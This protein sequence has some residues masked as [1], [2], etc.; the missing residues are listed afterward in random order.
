MPLFTG[1]GLAAYC[2]AVFNLLKHINTTLIQ[3]K[4]YFAIEINIDRFFCVAVIA[5]IWRQRSVKSDQAPVAFMLVFFPQI[6]LIAI[7][8]TIVAVYKIVKALFIKTEGNEQIKY[9]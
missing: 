4:D 8:K 5:R 3:V 9:F 1:S 6:I 7:R 2:F